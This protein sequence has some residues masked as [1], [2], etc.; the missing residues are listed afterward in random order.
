[1]NS[2]YNPEFH[3]NDVLRMSFPIDLSLKIKSI[4]ESYG[5]NRLWKVVPNWDSDI[6]WLSPSSLSEF[7]LFNDLFIALN[8]QN[9]LKDALKLEF[10]IVMYC[11]FIVKRSWCKKVNFHTDWKGT[12]LKAFTLITPLV[13]ESNELGLN[14]IKKDSSLGTYHY[15]LGEAIIFGEGFTHSSMPTSREREVLLL[16][17]T[18]GI[19]DMSYWPQLPKSI[20]SQSNLIRLPNGDFRVRNLNNC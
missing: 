3:A 9:L 12:G 2:F 6:C 10:D 20:Q 4:L 7:R 19:N 5:L 15:K 14:Y 8:V 17:F 16:S 11:G 13:E 1:M 18:F